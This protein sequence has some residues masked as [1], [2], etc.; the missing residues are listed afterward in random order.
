MSFNKP[1]IASAFFEIS[2]IFGDFSKHK[3]SAR[4]RQ[5]TAPVS[6]FDVKDLLGS[7]ITFS[8]SKATVWRHARRRLTP[9]RSDAARTT[10]FVDQCAEVGPLL[11]T[12]L[13]LRRRLRRRG[14]EM[15]FGRVV[16]W[17]GAVRD[18][19][20]S[21]SCGEYGYLFL[22]LY[23]ADGRGFAIAGL[24]MLRGVEIAMLKAVVLENFWF[25]QKWLFMWVFLQ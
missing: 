24:A 25:V 1:G 7:L 9:D 18:L 15:L 19:D 14:G 23:G 22:L 20:S 17:P 4:L 8:S 16:E 13:L 2:Q 12:S 3:T 11:S 10:V 6:I 21:L 5:P